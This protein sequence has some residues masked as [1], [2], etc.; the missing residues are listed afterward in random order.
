MGHE[1]P[2]TALVVVNLM[3]GGESVKL[4]SS[5]SKLQQNE[6]GQPTHQKA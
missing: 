1:T 2:P 3:A 4:L 6:E 5:L